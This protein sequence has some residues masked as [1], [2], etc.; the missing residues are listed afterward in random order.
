MI[1][2]V[3]PILHSILLELD[4]QSIDVNDY[5]K[6]SEEEKTMLVDFIGKC[7]KPILEQGDTHKHYL[8]SSIWKVI[9]ECEMEDEYEQADI[10]RRCLTHLEKGEW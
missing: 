1:V 2:M 9:K 8:M 3:N 4:T 5:F 10:M 7:F 6:W